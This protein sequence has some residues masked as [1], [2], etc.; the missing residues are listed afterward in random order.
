MESVKGLKFPINIKKE[1]FT[2]KTAFA[3]STASNNLRTEITQKKQLLLGEN[4]T[5]IFGNQI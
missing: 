5:K 1:V 4:N 2:A 3:I